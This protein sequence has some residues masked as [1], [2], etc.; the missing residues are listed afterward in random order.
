MNK[1]LSKE[2]LLDRGSCCDNG[3]LNC[4]Y[5]NDPSFT[6]RVEFYSGKNK[7][8]LGYTDW[9]LE[10]TTFYPFLLSYNIMG[11][12]DKVLIYAVPV[13]VGKDFRVFERLIKILIKE[14]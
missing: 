8:H 6:Y 7:H 14:D 3:C 13:E 1:P 5:P 9:V 2:Y 4:P 10:K 11:K 12:Y